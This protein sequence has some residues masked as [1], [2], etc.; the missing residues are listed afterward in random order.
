MKHNRTYSVYSRLRHFLRPKGVRNTDLNDADGNPLT[1]D[2][3]KLNQWSGYFS[4][5]LNTELKVDE[6]L[7]NSVSEAKTPDDEPH[8]LMKSLTSSDD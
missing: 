2:D 1:T 7:L 3:D 8:P 5:L 6:E 4:N